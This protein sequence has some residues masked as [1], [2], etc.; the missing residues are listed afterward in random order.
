MLQN[1]Q[2]TPTTEKYFNTVEDTIFLKI[3]SEK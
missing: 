2:K 3:N 1:L